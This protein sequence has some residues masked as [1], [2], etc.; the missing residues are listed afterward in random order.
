MKY[1]L[2]QRSITKNGKTTKVWYYWYYDANGKQVRKSCGENGKQC[3]VK[4]QAEAFLERLIQK[5][6]MLSKSSRITF[7]EFCKGFYDEDSDFMIKKKYHGTELS[8][9]TIY[10]RKHY[11]ELILSQFGTKFV[12]EVSGY[13]FDTWLVKL[14]LSCSV[15]N[16]IL[17][18]I[19]EIEQELYAKKLIQHVPLLERYKR[20]DTKEKDILTIDEIKKL[21]PLDENELY[22]VWRI[23]GSKLTKY[24]DI[25]F[26]TMIFTLLSTGMRSGEVR[27]LQ[28]NQF[29]AENAILINAA[30]NNENERVN[31]LKKGTNIPSKRKWRVVILPTR[32]VEMINRLKEISTHTQPNDFVFQ[33][34]GEPITT[35][36]LLEHL[37]GVLQKNGINTNERNITVHSLR[38]TYNT[39]MRQKINEK[40]LRLMVGHVSEGMTDYYD[41]SIA[42]DKL[43]QLLLNQEIINKVWD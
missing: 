10:Q 13:D 6:D 25:S 8:P 16:H 36:F 28:W 23:S 17:M 4:K 7:N 31:K 26:Y 3:T 1:H 27:A 14:E 37:I 9:N 35:Y 40:D 24:D 11:L 43:P 18:M 12:D 34:S 33:R 5:E 32:T 22:N 20:N 2:Y 15:K 38:F 19:T 30:I 21:F 29:V 42:I 39:I 41:R